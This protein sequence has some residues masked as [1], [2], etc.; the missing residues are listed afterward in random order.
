MQLLSF[1]AFQARYGEDRVRN[2]MSRTMGNVRFLPGSV[3]LSDK[4]DH[5]Y[6]VDPD[7]R[8]ENVKGKIGFNP[9]VDFI[10]PAIYF[11]HETDA[12]AWLLAWG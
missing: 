10:P 5:F 12:V 4:H 9:A 8:T 7:W 6:E 11:Q 2:W 1:A 3:L